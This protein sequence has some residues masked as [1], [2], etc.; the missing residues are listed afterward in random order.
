MKRRDL[1]LAAAGL[2]AAGRPLLAAA[3]PPSIEDLTAGVWDVVVAGSGLAGLTAAIAAREAGASRVL[4]IEK[5]PLVGGHSAFSS[6]SF[7]VLSP[8]LQAA[9]GIVDPIETWIADCRRIGGD[10]NESVVRSIIER[11]ESTKDWLASMGVDFSSVLFEALGGLRPRCVA[12]RG[13]MGGKHYIRVLNAQ[14]RESGVALRL[15]TALVSALPSAVEAAHVWRLELSVEG[16][17]TTEILSRSL[18]LA[19]GGFTANTS[20]R[21]LYDPRFG[22]RMQTTANPDG[23]LWDGATGDGIRIGLSAGATLAGMDNIIYLPYWGGRALDYAGA[24]IYINL[25][26]ERFV[27]ESAPVNVIAQAITY[28][29]EQEMW[30]ITDAKSIKGANIGSKFAT[31]R[32]HVSDSVAD[33]AKAMGIPAEVLGRTMA[34]YNRYARENR[35]PDFGKTTFAQ[36][37]DTPPFYWGREKLYVH[38]T[39]GGLVVDGSARVLDAQKNPIAG[40][41]AAGEVA[42]GIFGADRLGG[43]SLAQAAVLGREAGR[44]AALSL[45]A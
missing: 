30:V 20:I 22:A 37:I 34:R 8:R 40:L 44:S 2:L 35:D 12:P 14:G 4:V 3:A 42:G 26:G 7:A 5:G 6:G 19:T 15:N 10:I 25:K 21:L 32:L 1:V 16:G 13:G 18:V 39:L 17:R 27:N 28:E 36:T 23:T 29:P 43:M 9:Q 45:L 33:M 24:E 11:S 38:C 41:F 31:G